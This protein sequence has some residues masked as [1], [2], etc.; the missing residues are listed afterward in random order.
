LRFAVIGC[1]GGIGDGAFGDGASG[2]PRGDGSPTQ[3][4]GDIKTRPGLRLSSVQYV[5][6]IRDL[7]GDDGFEAELEDE[8][9]LITQRATR[10]GHSEFKGNAVHL[11]VPGRFPFAV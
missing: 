1:T 7:V 2:G 6:T 5:N 10:Q 3:C 11:G 4:S 8:P 9:G